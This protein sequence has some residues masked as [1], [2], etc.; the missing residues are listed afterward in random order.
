MCGILAVVAKSGQVDPAACRRALA[1][2]RW[3]GPDFAFFR[4]WEGRAF[5]GQTVLSITGSPSTFARVSA[6]GMEPAWRRVS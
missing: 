6:S 4:V 2:L 5:L 3:R 1:G